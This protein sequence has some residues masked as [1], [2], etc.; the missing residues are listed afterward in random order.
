[1]TTRLPVEPA[2]PSEVGMIPE[3]SSEWGWF[4]GTCHSLNA[5]G[6]MR[7]YSCAGPKPAPTPAEPLAPL[8]SLAPLAPAAP[9]DPLAQP[10]SDRRRRPVALIAVGALLIVAIVAVAVGFTVRS[11]AA[12]LSSPILAG[13]AVATPTPTDTPAPTPTA[14]ASPVPSAS[15]TAVP[16]IAPPVPTAINP[17][18]VLPVL[19]AKISG[20]T[21]KYYSITGSTEA[22]L[23]SQIM[24]KGPATCGMS[25]AA[26]CFHD[27][28][29]WSY[30]GTT[31]AGVCSV[32][33][34]SFTAKY[35]VTLPKW[36]G[37]ARVSRTLAAW[38]KTVF[39]H[40]A[41][42]EGQH[43]AIA[44]T[45]ASKMKAAIAA[46]SCDKSEQ[47]ATIAAL[48]SQLEAA[49]NAF[50]TSQGPYIFP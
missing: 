11:A 8:D 2:W 30:T 13:I 15:P 42:H 47:N 33:S 12:G 24:T 10:D 7:C 40:I 41:W 46:G 5:P 29:S 14:T 27:S 43:L 35:T 6:A 32:T 31:N 36:S 49:Q 34:V 1:M 21:I 38:W 9:L 23:I 28:F 4:C 25:D 3:P 17:E 44:R 26:G 45:Y 16:T 19:K 18:I 20:A 37:P 48:S 50:D 39:D 22:E